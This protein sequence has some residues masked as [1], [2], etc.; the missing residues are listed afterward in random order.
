MADEEVDWGMDESNDVDIWRGE[1]GEVGGGDD[2][3]LSLGGED[4]D[5]GGS[6][7]GRVDLR[8]SGLCLSTHSA[9]CRTSR[10]ASE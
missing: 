7:C 2:D 9:G 8:K 5:E 6:Q 3:V 4:G 10:Q 1:G